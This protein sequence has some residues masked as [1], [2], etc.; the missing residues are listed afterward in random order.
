MLMPSHHIARAEKSEVMLVLIKTPDPLFPCE[1]GVQLSGRLR[2]RARLR[3][4]EDGQAELYRLARLM[5]ETSFEHPPGFMFEI[6]RGALDDSP[7][8]PQITD[9]ETS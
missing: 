5:D 6:V 8:D 2:T 1:L 7:F 3:T 9:E 4:I